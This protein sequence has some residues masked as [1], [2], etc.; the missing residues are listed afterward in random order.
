MEKKRSRLDIVADMLATIAE[1]KGAIKPTH[2]MYKSNLAHGQMKQY[3]QYLEQ[4][5]CITRVKKG[6]QELIT[7]TDT[8]YSFLNKI[9]EMREF[10]EGFGI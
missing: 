8:G 6:D 10:E 9:R 2:L 1:K 5:N 4:R 7:I 3:L